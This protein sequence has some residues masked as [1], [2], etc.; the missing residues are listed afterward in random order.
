MD[1]DFY[2]HE[3]YNLNNLYKNRS[4]KAKRLTKESDYDQGLRLWEKRNESGVIDT[5]DL[6]EEEKEKL[7][8]YRRELYRQR[9]YKN[10][11]V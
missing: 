10:E 3:H 9:R 2:S 6:T 5:T 1:P 7:L 11:Q 8:R 4:N